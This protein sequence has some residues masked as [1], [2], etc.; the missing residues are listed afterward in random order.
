MLKCY[1]EQPEPVVPPQPRSINSARLKPENK[2]RLSD[3]MKR[4]APDDARWVYQ[5]LK[6]EDPFLQQLQS[7]FGAS[8]PEIQVPVATVRRWLKEL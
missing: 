4:F 8:T 1:W 3:M 5:V 7:A 6:C 2:R